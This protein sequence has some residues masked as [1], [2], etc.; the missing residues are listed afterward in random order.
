MSGQQVGCLQRHQGHVSAIDCSNVVIGGVSDGARAPRPRGRAAPHCSRAPAVGLVVASGSFD[1]TVKI[2]D[3]KL[4]LPVRTCTGH[5]MPVVGARLLEGGRKMVS[6]G[7]DCVAKARIPRPAPRATAARRSR[8]RAALSARDHAYW[9]AIAVRPCWGDCAH[10]LHAHR[11]RGLR[12]PPP[13]HQVRQG[14]PPPPPPRPPPPRRAARSPLTRAERGARGQAPIV[15]TALSRDQAWL[16]ST[17]TDAAA[18][19]TRLG[20]DTSTSL[21]GWP[22]AADGRPETRHVWGAS[23]HGE[24]KRLAVAGRLP[25]SRAPRPRAA[26][27]ARS[28]SPLG[29]RQT[30]TDAREAGRGR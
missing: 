17:C 14:A 2:W 28:P 29:P 23:F 3:M 13:R 18:S 26:E 24:G 11:S 21:L 9:C 30:A 15:R 16:V 25:P 8:R 7:M 6:S 27:C 1:C 4:K 20:P 22:R 10:A 19:L 12:A 5:R